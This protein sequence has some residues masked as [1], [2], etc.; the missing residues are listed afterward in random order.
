VG[1]GEAAIMDVY[2]TSIHAINRTNIHMNQKVVIIGAGP[3]GLSLLDLVNVTG[4]KGILI[5]NIDNPLEFAENTIGVYATINSE[6]E[7][8]VSRVM[9]ITDDIGAD[10]VVD[11]VG[12][13]ASSIVISQAVE[14]VRRKGKIGLVGSLRRDMTLTV[15]WG[16]LMWGEIDLVPVS[17][18][19]HW[20]NDSEFKIVI[21]LLSDGKLHASEMI[22]HRFPLEKIN[23][24]FTVAADKRGT[25]SIKVVIDS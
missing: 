5:G 22:T 2:G 14:M 8:S 19:Y 9:E 23:E 11:C 12:G 24:A 1:Y 18:F 16:K 3:I 4:A 25:K 7:D 10:V 6:K 21:D 13:I 20:D 15:D 17:G